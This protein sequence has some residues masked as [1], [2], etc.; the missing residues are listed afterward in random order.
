[1]TE[2]WQRLPP[3]SALLMAVKKGDTDVA[4]VKALLDQ[5]AE[6]RQNIDDIKDPVRFT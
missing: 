4:A 6:E 2:K 1:M 5:L 3:R